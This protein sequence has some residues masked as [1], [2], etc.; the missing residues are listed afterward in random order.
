[1][2]TGGKRLQ[3]YRSEIRD[4]SDALVV[5]PHY[6]LCTVCLRGGCDSPPPGKER[7]QRI[8]D[9]VW[10][11]RELPIILDCP[12]YP[13][14]YQDIKSKEYFQRVKGELHNRKKDLDVLRR[15]GLVP[16]SRR[17]AWYLYKLM[18]ERIPTVKG[19]CIYDTATSPEWEGCPHARSGYYE[20]AREKGVGLF[21]PSRSK[22]EMQKAKENSV[23]SIYQ[24]ERLFIRPHHL[25]C[26][27]C[28]YG[29]GGSAPLEKD[30][31]YEVLRR[32]QEDPDTPITLIEGCGMI[33]PP[34][35]SYNPDSNLCD[36]VCGL[37]R[38]Y[39]KDLDVFQKLGLAPGATMKAKDLFRLLFER[40]KTSME[41]CGYGD[42]VV[43]SHE[44]AICGNVKTGDYEKGREKGIFPKEK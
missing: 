35:P 8:L 33:C 32:I 39:K 26:I 22:G 15:L 40:I 12:L 34:C 3:G 42:G 31:L 16:G 44:W 29:S 10:R 7:I 38:D 21:V 14:H 20:R 37:V 1:M 23:R 24:D 11:N 13:V 5:R 27:T 2:V 6:L 9:H 18:L 41:I 43:T 30:N 17:P 28:F 25:M 19:I 36:N 4:G